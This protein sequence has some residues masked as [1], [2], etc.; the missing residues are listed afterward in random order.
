M[1][2]NYLLPFLFESKRLY[3]NVK[4]IKLERVIDD[5]FVH[6]IYD[7]KNIKNKKLFLYLLNKEKYLYTY[8][9]DKDFIVKLKIDDS[10]KWYIDLLYNT[11]PEFISHSDL[12]HSFIQKI[13]A[14]RESSRDL[15]YSLILNIWFSEYFRIEYGPTALPASIVGD[16]SILRQIGA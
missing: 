12:L 4:D 10:N 1:Q 7:A 16:S 2:H 6:V 14:A 9:Y 13:P 11:S 3:E 5:L 15:F 8:Y